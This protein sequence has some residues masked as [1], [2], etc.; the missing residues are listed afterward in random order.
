MQ[1][2]NSLITDARRHNLSRQLGTEQERG[3]SLTLN[4]NRQMPRSAN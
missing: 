3:R 2:H 4:R 1:Y